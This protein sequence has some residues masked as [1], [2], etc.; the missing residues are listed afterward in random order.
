MKIE[1]WPDDPHFDARLFWAEENSEDLSA[2]VFEKKIF[3]Q[4]MMVLSYIEEAPRTSKEIAAHFQF[5]DGQARRTLQSIRRRGVG[6][7]THREKADDCL[8]YTVRSKPD[9]I[10]FF[11]PK[12]VNKFK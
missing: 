8:V 11:Y 7:S 1:P 2:L 12:N 9:R 4:D 5:D 10:A 6:F 3:D